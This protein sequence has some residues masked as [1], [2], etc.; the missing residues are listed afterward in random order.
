MKIFTDLCK[1]RK[2]HTGIKTHIY[3][4]AY[5]FGFFFFPQTLY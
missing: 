1:F 5:L 2:E 4:N 3:N